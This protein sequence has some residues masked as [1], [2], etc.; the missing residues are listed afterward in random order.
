MAADGRVFDI[1]ACCLL[2]CSRITS[3]CSYSFSS[4]HLMFA[5]YFEVASLML[6]A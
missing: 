6:S 4:L 2:Y 3:C 5:I 1:V